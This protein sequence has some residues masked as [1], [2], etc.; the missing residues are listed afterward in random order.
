MRVPATRLAVLL[1]LG[2]L[3][4]CATLEGGGVGFEASSSPERIDACA[5]ALIALRGAADDLR[6]ELDETRRRKLV[7]RGERGGSTHQVDW[8]P[9]LEYLATA[10]DE[11]GGW[12]SATLTAA[13]SAHAAPSSRA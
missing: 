5:G 12:I 11:V 1:L 2:A 13:A 9:A 4:A 10:L 6:A 7:W 3:F 8:N